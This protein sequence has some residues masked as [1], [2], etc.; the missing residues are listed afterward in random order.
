MT[1]AGGNRLYLPWL[2]SA[3]DRLRPLAWPMLRITAGLI[4]IPHGVPKL[5]GTFAPVLAKNVLTPLGLP[6]PIYWAYFLGALEIFGGILLAAGFLTRLF[7]LMFAVETA[8]I[9]IFV[10]LPKGWIYS[11][12]GGGAEF[13]A[14]L[15]VLYL[16][17][18]FKGAGNYSID[19]VLKQ[20]L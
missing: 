15:F 5:F 6:A 16:A 3:Y 20:E 10:S 1:D 2:A 14:L 8:I 7:A 13:V 9:V 12:P 11:V 18:V 19:S 4:M 17:F